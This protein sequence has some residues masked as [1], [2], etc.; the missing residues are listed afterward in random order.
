MLY[1]KYWTP[2]SLNTVSNSFSAAK[3][4]ISMLIGIAIEEGKIKSI[5]EPASNYLPE[6]KKR[7]R[8]KITIKDLLL[9][10]SG[11]DWNESGKNPYLIMPR[12]IM[13]MI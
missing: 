8:E 1:E 11:L 12:D 9:M 4:V 2:H 6:Y 7:G 3:S 13:V 10:A 5:E